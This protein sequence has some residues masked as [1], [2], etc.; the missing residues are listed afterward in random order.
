MANDDKRDGFLGW[1]G[2]SDVPNWEV[3]RPLGRLIGVMLTLAF[4]LL[5][6]TAL[7]AAFAVTWHTIRLGITGATEGINLGAGA[8]VAALL[9]SPFL[10]WST[11]KKKVT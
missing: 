4:P 1:L 6:V 3:A 8:L 10:I 9:G 2:I 7:V 5:F 11:I